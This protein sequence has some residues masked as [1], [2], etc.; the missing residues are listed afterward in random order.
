MDILRTKKRN[1]RAA[2][3]ERL[4]APA[5]I[6]QADADQ[7]SKGGARVVIDPGASG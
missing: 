4:V 5:G 7:T 3:Y 6:G 1:C 2:V